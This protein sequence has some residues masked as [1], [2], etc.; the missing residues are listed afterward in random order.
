MKK[1]VVILIFAFLFLY[2]VF[3]T[4][5]YYGLNG[6]YFIPIA[7]TQQTGVCEIGVSSLSHPASTLNIYPYS[8]RGYWTIVE[9]VELGITNTALYYIKYDQQFPGFIVTAP[10]GG[11]G[12]V[13][14]ITNTIIPI[15]PSIKLAFT[16]EAVANGSLAVGIEYPYGIFMLFDYSL[17]FSSDFSLYSV[18]GLS[19]TIATLYSMAG[20]RIELPYLPIALTL[21][22]AYGGRTELLT[23]TQEAFFSCGLLYQLTKQMNLDYVFRIDADTIRRMS[24][25]FNIKF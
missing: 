20:I 10:A 9:G 16:D 8:F 13:A 21:E 25:G 3:P 24:F 17:V 6:L 11:K 14:D 19:T 5:S 15:I 18:A 2:N 7:R 12:F 23:S 1:Y 4:A 22:G